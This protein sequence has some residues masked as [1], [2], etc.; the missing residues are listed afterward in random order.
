MSDN[1]KLVSPDFKGCGPSLDEL[2]KLVQKTER[3]WEQILNE[4]GDNII[5]FRRDFIDSSYHP[6]VYHLEIRKP[7]Q[8]FTMTLSDSEGVISHFEGEIVERLYGKLIS[9]QQKLID[10]RFKIRAERAKYVMR[11][12]R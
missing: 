5:G 4:E 3:G 6:N 10:E 12:F 9:C 8:G 11:Y 1:Y 2:E 7:G